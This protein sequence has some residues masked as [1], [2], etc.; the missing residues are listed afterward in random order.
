M[1]TPVPA[2][3]MEACVRI[4]LSITLLAKFETRT[5]RSFALTPAREQAIGTRSAYEVVQT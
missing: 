2:D 3:T 5:A 1:S 4:H